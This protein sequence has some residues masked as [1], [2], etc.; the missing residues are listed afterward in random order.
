MEEG[1]GHSRASRDAQP[2]DPCR[3]DGEDFAH[4]GPCPGKGGK[5]WVIYSLAVGV[6]LLQTFSDSWEDNSPELGPLWGGG[7]RPPRSPSV[8]LCKALSSSPRSP[9]LPV[10]RQAG[11]SLHQRRGSAEVC[12]SESCSAPGVRGTLCLTEGARVS[13]GHH[14]EVITPP[15]PRHQPPR[16]PDALS[17]ARETRTPVPPGSSFVCFSCATRRGILQTCLAYAQE[18]GPGAHGARCSRAP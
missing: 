9:L 12:F 13:E 11:G 8:S 3:C 7:A 14:A 10:D 1:G 16:G 2:P 4:L 15:N 5:S 6:T 17:Q 18:S